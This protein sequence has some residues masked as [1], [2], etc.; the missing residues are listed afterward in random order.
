MY[1]G[2]GGGARC[3]VRDNEFRTHAEGILLAVE[4]TRSAYAVSRKV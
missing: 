2:E 1:K 4:A 3:T